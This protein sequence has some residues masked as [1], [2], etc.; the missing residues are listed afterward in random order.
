MLTSTGNFS[1]HGSEKFD[2]LFDEPL[3]RGGLNSVEGCCQFGGTVRLH[4]PHNLMEVK[5]AV[6]AVVGEGFWHSEIIF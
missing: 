5:K 2:V 1:S 4:V 6:Y 3:I